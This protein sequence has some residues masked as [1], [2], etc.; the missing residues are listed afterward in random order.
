M[1]AIECAN[2]HSVT[3]RNI[4]LHCNKSVKL[5]TITTYKVRIKYT[6]STCEIHISPCSSHKSGLALSSAFF[7]AASKAP[8]APRFTCVCTPNLFCNRYSSICELACFF[9]LL[10][11]LLIGFFRKISD[12][13][14]G[15]VSCGCNPEEDNDC[16]NNDKKRNRQIES[17]ALTK[18][19]IDRERTVV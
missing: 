5:I 17:A 2:Y 8:D 15:M 4:K 19:N 11:S 1:M 18:N 10:P 6:D 12:V 14:K 7:T 13:Y 3:V 9:I 16:V